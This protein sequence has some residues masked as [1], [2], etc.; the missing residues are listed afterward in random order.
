MTAEHGMD[1]VWIAERLRGVEDRAKAN[2]HRLDE[3]EKRQEELGDLIASVKV[4]AMRQESVETDVKEIKCDVKCLKELPARRWESV[5]EKIILLIV[6]AG[7]SM[8]LT[9][10]GLVS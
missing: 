6:G 3:V 4:L 5:V 2:S 1:E 7:V 8:L 10:L 9:K